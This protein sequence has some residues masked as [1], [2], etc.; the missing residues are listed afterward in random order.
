VTRVSTFRIALRSRDEYLKTE[1]FVLS[2]CRYMYTIH[3][4]HLAYF[5]SSSPANVALMR[6]ASAIAESLV[7]CL[8]LSH[9]RR[10]SQQDVWS[11][12]T[13]HVHVSYRECVHY[14]H[15]VCV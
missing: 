3:V 4:I 8:F 2:N 13:S 15:Y 1:H 11:V 10:I 12:L 9:M 6:G 14:R 7:S 5:T